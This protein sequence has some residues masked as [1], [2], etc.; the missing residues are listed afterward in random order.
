MTRSPSDG[1]AQITFLLLSQR[2]YGIF[3]LETKTAT[4]SNGKL[5]EAKNGRSTRHF[6]ID[7]PQDSRRPGV[8]ARLR[9]RAAHR[10]NQRRSA[11][12]QSG[13]SLPRSAEARARRRDRI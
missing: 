4:L 2:N 13:H 11:H 9:D 1:I 6:G 7:G 5:Y 8:A 3:L 10:T 12:G